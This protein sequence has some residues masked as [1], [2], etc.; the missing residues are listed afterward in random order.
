MEIK[1]TLFPAF[2]CQNRNTES[3]HQ[4][5]FFIYEY[6]HPKFFFK[7]LDNPFIFA[8]ASLKYYRRKNL[9][10]LCHIVQIVAGD[11]FA[12]SGNNLLSGIAYLQLMDQIGFC[13]NRTSGCHRG[14]SFG[15]KGYL[16]EVFH[17]HA[18]SVS[19][20]GKKGSRSCGA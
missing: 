17:L 18:K 9:L 4:V 10:S 2:L 11:C 20:A 14:S 7:H 12:Q 6:R 19:L 5:T 16:A 1:V 8:H 13:K 15:R 3:S